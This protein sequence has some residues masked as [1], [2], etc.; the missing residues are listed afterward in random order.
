MVIAVGKML[1]LL[2]FRWGGGGRENL[3]SVLV[4]VGIRRREGVHS[5]P[6]VLPFPSRSNSLLP[7]CVM[8]S[9]VSRL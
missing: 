3:S 8:R 5:L 1:R 9:L 6:L 2:N 4:Q 7:A